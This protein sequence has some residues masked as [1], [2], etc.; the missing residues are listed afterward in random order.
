MPTSSAASRTTPIGVVLLNQ[1]GSSIA[2]A[3]LLVVYIKAKRYAVA[4][5]TSIWLDPDTGQHCAAIA[6][7]H[8]AVHTGNAYPYACYA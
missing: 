2:A 7:Q 6:W 3:A 8:S 1:Q 4:R 5:A